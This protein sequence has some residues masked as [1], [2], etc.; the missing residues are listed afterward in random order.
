MGVTIRVQVQLG[1]TFI[2]GVSVPLLDNKQTRLMRWKRVHDIKLHTNE[3]E[4][5]FFRLVDIG[6]LCLHLEL[7]ISGC[8]I[9][10]R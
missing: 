6:E 4:Q 5:G 10:K 7:C 3:L 1:C 9:P 2:R 8:G